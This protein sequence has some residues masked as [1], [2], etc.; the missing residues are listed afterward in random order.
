MKTIFGLITIFLFTA[1]TIIQVNAKIDDRSVVAI[2][3]FD[4]NSGNVARDSSGKGHDG[5][6]K[7]SVKWT[8]G[9]FLSALEFPG[10]V[11]SFV[12]VPHHEDFNLLTFTMLTWIKAENTGQRQEI[13]MKRA[14]GAVNSQ[15]LHLQIESGRTVVDVGFTADNQWATGLFGKTNVTTGDWFH[16]AA[17]YDKQTLRLYVNGIDD[18]QQARNTKPDNNDAPV[19]I[20]A[21]FASGTTPLKGALDDVGIF[22]VALNVDDINLIMKDGLKKTIGAKA[23]NKADKLAS[24]WGKIKL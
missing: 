1:L 22:N 10:Q 17:T 4:E 20:G 19:T 23:I 2:W 12:L 3:L 24:T 18:G 16:V 11:G 9:K 5:E 15:N 8:N 14:E 6:I 7:G 21:V 13:I